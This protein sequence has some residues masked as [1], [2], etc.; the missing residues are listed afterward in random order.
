MK[1]KIKKILFLTLK[2]CGNL[3]EYGHHPGWIPLIGLIG[4]AYLVAGINGVLLS[5]A[6][7][8]PCFLFGAYDRASGMEA[9][10]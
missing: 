2:G 7:L 3:P 1:C 9:K 10:Q 8:V 5:G 6:L 4:C